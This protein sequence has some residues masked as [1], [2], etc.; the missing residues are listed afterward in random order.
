[1]TV[2][3]SFKI[4]ELASRSGVARHTIRFYERTGVL[5]EPE[6]TS[7]GYRMYEQ[8]AVE[9]LEFIGKGQALGLRLDDIKEVLAISE[10]GRAPCGHVREL[11]QERLRETE[12]RLRELEDLRAT[13][14]GT[15]E[16]FKDPESLEPG[17]RCAV[18]EK[19]TRG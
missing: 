15:L 17:C 10:G 14:R 5:P 9:R 7:S 18:I 11:L 8:A 13:L 2:L 3:E 16:R 6:R 1:M 19:A 12:V 4:G